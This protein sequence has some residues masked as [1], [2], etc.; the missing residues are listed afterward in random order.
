MILL[1]HIGFNKDQVERR[2]HSISVHARSSV[3]ALALSNLSRCSMVWAV[4]HYFFLSAS[5]SPDNT[6]AYKEPE[7]GQAAE[8]QGD[9]HANMDPNIYKT[10]AL[11]SPAY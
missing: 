6:N 11:I 2:V 1:Q 3:S 5:K 8:H 10:D 9:D 7:D 4:S